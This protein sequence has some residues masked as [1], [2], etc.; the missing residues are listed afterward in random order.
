MNM[1]VLLV[2]EKHFYIVYYII[3]LRSKEADTGI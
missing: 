1:S 2:L 3:I